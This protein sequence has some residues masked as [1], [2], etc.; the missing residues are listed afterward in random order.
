[1][2]L[3]RESFWEDVGKGV[4]RRHRESGESKRIHANC[5]SNPS[6]G[7]ERFAWI[8]KIRLIRDANDQ[9]LSYFNRG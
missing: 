7:V 4:V 5:S 3:V 2:V 1:M 6:T 9:R 8:R